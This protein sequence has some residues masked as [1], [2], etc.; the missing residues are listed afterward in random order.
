MADS[1]P[2]SVLERSF[3]CKPKEGCGPI[4]MTI[5]KSTL[6]DEYFDCKDAIYIKTRTCYFVLCSNPKGPLYCHKFTNY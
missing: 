1:D 6:R 3:I 5:F 2:N 4:M